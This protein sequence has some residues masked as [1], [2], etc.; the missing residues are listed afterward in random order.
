MPACE[1]SGMS[2]YDA[3]GAA[4]LRRLASVSARLDRPSSRAMLARLRA[5]FQILSREMN[6]WVAHSEFGKRRHIHVAE[7]GERVEGR[8]LECLQERGLPV[9]SLGK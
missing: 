6:E 4:F 7:F 9:S 8:L 3:Q 5:E 2:S 1:T